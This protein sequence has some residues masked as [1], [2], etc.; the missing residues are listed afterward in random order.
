MRLPD[1]LLH[2]LAHD[3]GGGSRLGEGG[4]ADHPLHRLVGLAAGAQ[5]VEERGEEDDLRVEPRPF[6][7]LFNAGGAQWCGAGRPTR[8]RAKLSRAVPLWNSTVTS[9]VVVVKSSPTFL[10]MTTHRDSRI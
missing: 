8:L 10:L 3:V 4:Q 9:V 7:G 2:R 5:Q 1:G 6:T